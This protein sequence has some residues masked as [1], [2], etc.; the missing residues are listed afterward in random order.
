MALVVG[1]QFIDRQVPRGQQRVAVPNKDMA[2]GTAQ[3]SGWRC[4][5]VCFAG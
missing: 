3:T 5:S 2:C 4:G 1:L